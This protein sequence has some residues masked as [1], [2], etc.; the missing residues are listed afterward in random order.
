MGSGDAGGVMVLDALG[1]M[2]TE[3]QWL[4]WTDAGGLGE[5]LDASH[6]DLYEGSVVVDTSMISVEGIPT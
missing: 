6:P 4:G 3:V 2:V 1:V 5:D